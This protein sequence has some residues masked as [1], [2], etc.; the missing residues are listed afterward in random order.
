MGE[1]RH[2]VLAGTYPLPRATRVDPPVVTA[3]CAVCGMPYR[4]GC[5]SPHEHS[6]WGGCYDADDIR[7]IDGDGCYSH[8]ECAKSGEPCREHEGRD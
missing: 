1:A 7:A 6:A 8:K 5:Y 4:T 3:Y 2:R